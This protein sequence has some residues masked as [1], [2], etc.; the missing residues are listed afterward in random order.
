MADINTNFVISANAVQAQAALDKMG[1][2]FLA[3]G[4][5]G[6]RAGAAIESSFAP[7]KRGLISISQQLSRARLELVGFFS[8]RAGV[9]AAKSI[10]DIADRMKLIDSRLKLATKSQEEFEAAQAGTLAIARETG[11]A[12]EDTAGLYTRLADSMRALGATQQDTLRLTSTINK[13]IVV[14]GAGAATS[15]AGIQQLAQAF[16][17]GVLRGDEFNSVME[18]T[19]R[20]SQAIADGLGV[21]IGALR[22]MAKAGKLT[23]DVVAGALQGQADII[24]R[25]FAQM[26]LTIGRAMQ[27]LR[28]EF[29]QF[30][31]RADES[32]SASRRLADGIQYL[33]TH[34]D[35]L[36]SIA[37]I[38][39][40]SIAT[41]FGGAAMLKIVAGLG[42]FAAGLRTGA[43]AV[44]ALSTA[45]GLFAG[46]SVLA[47]LNQLGKASRYGL[48][49]FM[50]F[51]GY[52]V[53]SL[54]YEIDKV[55]IGIAN[56]VDRFT[57]LDYRDSGMIE[58]KI[59]RLEKLLD[60]IPGGRGTGAIKTTAE[61]VNE[62]RVARI[63]A[64]I[65]KLNAEL[66]QVKAAEAKLRD[67][68][69][70]GRRPNGQPPAQV[71]ELSEEEKKLLENR[72]KLIAKA[73]EQA[74]TTGM[75]A[76]Q[77]ALYEA[78][79]LGATEADR[80]ALNAYYDII[81]AKERRAE[82][83][84]DGEAAAK[85]AAETEQQRRERIASIV[86]GYREQADQ[87]GM[88]ARQIAQYTAARA[89]AAAADRAAIDAAYNLIETEE[90]RKQLAEEQAQALEQQ[91]EAREA[92]AEAI[93]QQIDPFRT[94][95]QEMARARDLFEMR[96]L[97]T[98]EFEAAAA[99]IRERIQQVQ[100]DLERAKAGFSEFA[101][102]AARNIQTAFAD[103]LFDPF[104]SGI[105]GMLKSFSDALRRMASEALAAEIGK[106][107]LGDFGSSTGSGSGKIGGLL[108][109]L[110][111]A[112]GF[113]GGGYTGSGGK[114]EAAGVVHRGEY[115]FSADSVR[116]LGVGL[117]E[118]LHNASRP[119]F[120]I[121]RLAY[122]SGGLVA[123]PPA[124]LSGQAA[125]SS[126]PSL[127][128]VNVIDPAMAKDFLDS[129]SGE[130]VI[131]NIIQRNAG[132]VRQVLA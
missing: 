63:K 130:Q 75:S 129:P 98:A 127:R 73:K 33:A 37:V 56:L 124:A 95:N 18:N 47:K 34:I 86:D 72:Q 126:A 31:K 8:V 121:P 48:L 38:G 58:Q 13:A 78:A 71:K 61:R 39:G 42:R 105:R 5:A 117:L 132:A 99:N 4:A 1:R 28:T 90:Q 114:Y 3:V 65:E 97:S 57:G 128:I 55:S 68:D 70:S 125:V 50:L 87:I 120:A 88:T 113:A 24:N 112:F 122:A 76:R 108:G 46:G 116:N 115:V 93:R 30:V 23:A 92:D 2:D 59:T 45:V 100:A 118:A 91:V 17:S 109:G 51:G 103:F 101:T 52:E 54:I 19:P 11:Q 41:A 84:K 62:P 21:P 111:S 119:S 82:A 81:E 32:T 40:A 123:A 9:Q 10:G 85:R 35:D 64:E 7:A 69:S 16:A 94:L 67:L 96:V 77:I 60:E 80:K 106:K 89:G 79:Q 6:K 74:E 26:P 12:L 66:A 110:F 43:G 102:Q 131:V 83:E 107:L 36:V 29:A 104:E 49:G 14:S 20:I 27:N 22:E 15:A 44:G 25:E 53:G